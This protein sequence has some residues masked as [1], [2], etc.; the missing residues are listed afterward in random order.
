MYGYDAKT[1]GYFRILFLWHKG[2]L[3]MHD[4][5]LLPNK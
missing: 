4:H 3:C 1:G 5:K 2:G